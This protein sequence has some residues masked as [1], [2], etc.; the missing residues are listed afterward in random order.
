MPETNQ[1]AGSVKQQEDA[2]FEAASRILDLWWVD[3]TRAIGP[4]WG[5][6]AKL[7]VLM[8]IMDSTFAEKGLELAPHTPD[9]GKDAA[10]LLAAKAYV[11]AY[12]CASRN[13]GSR[14]NDLI[15]SVNRL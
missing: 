3:T 5:D 14:L 1:P 11:T 2:F 7:R 6:H 15:D 4:S 13:T 12:N 10:I 9:S 8:S